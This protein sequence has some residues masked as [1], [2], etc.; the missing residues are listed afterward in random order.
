MKSLRI[1]LAL[2]V[3]FL[4]ACGDG[5]IQSPNFTSV[6]ATLTVTANDAD[7]LAPDPG[8]PT[9]PRRS[10][11]G[12]PV[13]LIVT[14]G[15][16]N[17]PGSDQEL[18]LQAVSDASFTVTPSTLALVENGALRGTGMGTVSVVATRDGISSEPFSLQIVAAV[19]DSI[20]VEPA[21]VNI[22][23]N[24]TADFAA[25]GTFTDGSARPV[26][27]NWATTPPAQISVAPMVGQQTTATPA[28]DSSGTTTTLTAS[29]T[30]EDGREVSGSATISVN[31]E[32]LVELTG[33]VPSAQTVAPGASAE[34]TAQGSF[35]DG[36]DTRVGDVS[37]DL[38]LWSSL[39][40]AVATIEED[41]GVAT[42]VAGGQ[43]TTVTATLK[44]SV[45]TEP[46]AQRSASGTITVSDARCTT[47]LVEAEGATAT[48][49]T[50]GLCLLC[51]IEDPGNVIDGDLNTAATISVPIGLLDGSATLFVD[52][53]PDA[54]NFPAGPRAGFVVAA[55]AGLLSLELLSEIQ[56]GTRLDGVAAEAAG[57]STTNPLA[58]SLLGV[59][60]GQDAALLSFPTTLPYDGLSL[61]F[62]AGVATV[63]PTVNVFQACATAVDTDAVVVE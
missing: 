28:I 38:V 24:E 46:G 53:D 6:L 60:G 7:T 50:A 58:I 33:V 13:P 18:N 11:I 37:D 19:L 62:L 22:S 15:F 17:P 51:Q 8:N 27:V 9:G 1:M 5:E 31:N 42:G 41:T 2:A 4:A 29:A 12:R 34:F 54:E 32:V 36:T 25:T 45:I 61:T 40:P 57:A 26:V 23:I 14:G 21:T 35:S 48:V 20:A 56:V 55:P 59:I 47:P 63:L 52:A 10:P 30:S 3:T 44:D 43:Q 16:S 39:N 49:D